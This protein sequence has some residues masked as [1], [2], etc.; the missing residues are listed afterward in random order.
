MF[1]L[2]TLTM[3]AL[4]AATMTV[5]APQGS[6]FD[7]IC[8]GRNAGWFC[9]SAGETAFCN[10][11]HRYVDGHVCGRGTCCASTSNGTAQCEEDACS[12][13]GR[14]RPPTA[15]H[16][17]PPSLFEA[18]QDIEHQHQQR[19][20]HPKRKLTLPGIFGRHHGDHNG[21]AIKR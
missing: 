6:P 11:D 20:E 13:G 19:R 7:E 21:N 2:K 14:A 17:P 18:R 10:R 16:R 1:S 9:P 4:A 5:A 15:A 12:A 8:Q 3:L